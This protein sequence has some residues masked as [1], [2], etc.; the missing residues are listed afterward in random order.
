MALEGAATA[1]ACVDSVEA[2]ADSIQELRNLAS[3]PTAALRGL[4]TCAGAGVSFELPA[5]AL[6]PGSGQL[7]MG[8][9]KDVADGQLDDVARGD[10]AMY[11][12][13]TC[14]ARVAVDL[15][16]LALQ[17]QAHRLPGWR[18]YAPLVLRGPG[19]GLALGTHEGAKRGDAYRAVEVREDGQTHPLGPFGRL[20]TTGPGGTRGEQDPSEF[21][22]RRG[23]AEPDTRMEELA[24]IGLVLGL[25]PEVSYYLLTGDIEPGIGVGGVLEGGYNASQYVPAADEIWARVYLGAALAEQDIHVYSLEV[26]PEG[27]FYLSGGLAAFAGVGFSFAII[28]APAPAPAAP[29]A[30]PDTADAT[31]LTGMNYGGVLAVGLDYALSPAWNVR[32][33][34]NYRQAGSK[35]KLEDK[36]HTTEVD[37]GLLSAARGGLGLSYTF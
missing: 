23:E 25:R 6:A 18:L 20:A 9:C 22:F 5:E 28:D 7:R 21:R 2:I 30:G 16:T 1:S 31:R 35:A 26:V 11:K 34:A 27:T 8:F 17:K 36:D 13:A 32:L 14:R 15:A 4:A 29:A 19:F 12:V 33:Q 10:D 24:Q 37:A 3:S